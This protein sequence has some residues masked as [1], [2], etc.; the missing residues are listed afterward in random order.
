[1][2]LGTLIFLPVAACAPQE[3]LGNGLGLTLPWAE[4]VESTGGDELWECDTLKR[5]GSCVWGA[6]RAAKCPVI[7]VIVYLF[8]NI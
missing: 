7:Q 2:F 8:F 4:G 5:R 1:M 3:L 6:R